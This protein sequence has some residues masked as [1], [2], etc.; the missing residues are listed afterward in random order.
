MTQPSTIEIQEFPLWAKMKE[1]RGLFSFDLEITARCNNDCR[2]CY[3]NLPAGDMEARLKELTL[4][5]IGSIADQAVALGALWV[6]ISG[7]EP[8]L[9]DDFEEIYML[10]KRKGLLVSVF[11]N[12]TLIRERHIALFQKYPPRDIEVTVYGATERTYERVT[13]RPGSFAAF[14]LGLKR[15]LDAG[16]K[17]RLKAMAIRSNFHE[18]PAIAVFC[19]NY[20]KDYFRFDPQLHLRFDGNKERNRLIKSERLTPEEIV[21]LEK[22]D[23]ERF[24]S[25]Q[26]GCDTLINDNFAHI[27]CDHLF[28]CGLGNSSFNVGYEGTFRLCSSLWAPETLYDLRRWRL[29]DAWEG[30]VPKVRDMRSRRP[31]YLEK[32]RSCAIVNLCL[33]CPAHSYLE[34]GELDSPIEYFCQVAR[35]RAAAIREALHK[36]KE[37]A[38]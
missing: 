10:L 26:K 6:L 16:V 30:F 15:L 14:T 31:E 5:E 19:R 28:H 21:A 35:A 22:A 33:W 38:T 17:V 9:R 23:D 37:E 12:A 25:L 20:T 29:R 3:I 13:G 32:C 1:H 4:E 7:G 24:A 2:H 18:L 11:T 36:G 8:L 27:G 34:T